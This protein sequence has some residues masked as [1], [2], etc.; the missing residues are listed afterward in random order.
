VGRV[1]ASGTVSV[2]RVLG[3]WDEDTLTA[4]AAPAVEA[5]L[6][7]TLT[8]SD[9]TPSLDYLPLDVT[10]AV[11]AWLAGAPDHGLALT[12]DATVDAEF[13]SKESQAIAHPMKLEVVLDDPR[14]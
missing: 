3:P 12:G 4:A 6:P 14:D 2:H 8:L 13:A 1:L 9:G 11:Q 10:P 5:A 7:E